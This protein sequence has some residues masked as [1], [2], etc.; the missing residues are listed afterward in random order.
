MA[1]AAAAAVL[2]AAAAAAPS[3]SAAYDY[4]HACMVAG[5][6][7]TA[8]LPPAAFLGT[9]CQTLPRMLDSWSRQGELRRGFMPALVPILG[10]GS[11]DDSP[12]SPWFTHMLSANVPT[13]RAMAT[14]WGCISAEV[15][16][17]TLFLT[18]PLNE[19]LKQQPR[20][21]RL[22]TFGRKKHRFKH[23]GAA[24]LDRPPSDPLRA[25]WTNTD[26]Y[27]SAWVTAWP[28]PDLWLND[29]EFIEVST[30]N[31]GLPSPA[32]TPLVGQP[33]G[34]TPHATR[35]IRLSPLRSQL[36]W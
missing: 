35:C 25:A 19:A 5:S 28:T 29:A 23:L 24:L 9:L 31:F 2:F 4:L 27:A 11:F 13:S 6:A 3:P 20:V 7:R 36:A 8:T 12:L 17:P 21:Q 16:D 22:I 14:A 10:A 34:R 30:R 15:D 18:R 1:A 26:E 32:C 33:I